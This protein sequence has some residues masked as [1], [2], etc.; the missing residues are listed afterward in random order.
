MERT[1]CVWVD[2]VPY[3]GIQTTLSVEENFVWMMDA[4]SEENA[5]TTDKFAHQYF[6][7]EIDVVVPHNKTSA[8]LLFGP[9]G[10]KEER[11]SSDL[12]ALSSVWFEGR[13]L[14]PRLSEAGP[15]LVPKRL[16]WRRLYDDVREWDP[17]IKVN[18]MCLDWGC[19]SI[20]GELTTQRTCAPMTPG[21]CD[22]THE[23]CFA[24]AKSWCEE[25]ERKAARMLPFGAPYQS[26]LCPGISH[27][28]GTH[29]VQICLSMRPGTSA[30]GPKFTGTGTAASGA[31]GDDD[32]LPTAVDFSG[33][34]NTDLYR[35]NFRW[36]NQEIGSDYVE[37]WFDSNTGWLTNLDVSRN[38]NGDGF[39]GDFWQIDLTDRAQWTLVG[40]RLR[41]R[42]G[43][44]ERVTRFK[45]AWSPVDDGN[46]WQWVDSGQEFEGNNADDY[47]I[48]KDVRFSERIASGVRFIRVYPTAFHRRASLR[49]SP[50]VWYTPTVADQGGW[51]LLARS[52]SFAMGSGSDIINPSYIRDGVTMTMD[53]S[54]RDW[55]E[56]KVASVNWLQAESGGYATAMGWSRGARGI[57]ECARRKEACN[58]DS[59]V[60]INVG[61]HMTGPSVTLNIDDLAT[62][63][64]SNRPLRCPDIVDRSNWFGTATLP[65][66]LAF[67]VSV[68]NANGQ[69]IVQRTDDPSS[70]WSHN[71]QFYCHYETA[72]LVASDPKQRGYCR[73]L[74]GPF[75]GSITFSLT[76]L[77]DNDAGGGIV[78]IKFRI[79]N[80]DWKHWQQRYRIYID[81]NEKFVVETRGQENRKDQQ[82]GLYGP[83]H[84]CGH[85]YYWEDIDVVVERT[86]AIAIAAGTMKLTISINYPQWSR[87]DLYY[88]DRLQILTATSR[89]VDDSFAYFPTDSERLLA[90]SIKKL[91]YDDVHMSQ[92]LTTPGRML[93]DV[94]QTGWSKPQTFVYRWSADPV[95]EVSTLKPGGCKSSMDLLCRVAHGPFDVKTGKEGVSKSFE[96]HEL[97]NE[98]SITLRFWAVDSWDG[99]QDQGIIQVDGTT[100]WESNSQGWHKECAESEW[101]HGFYEPWN[102]IGGKVCYW[103]VIL[104][105]IPHT[106]SKLRLEIS[107]PNLRGVHSTDEY[108]AFS[109]VRIYASLPSGTGSGL[110]AIV[111]TAR[112]PAWSDMLTLLYSDT[113]LDGTVKTDGWNNQQT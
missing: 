7:C 53:W 109:D 99:T 20:K 88:I 38:N 45:V 32:I 69:I 37:G 30:V 80:V 77:P 67:V 52:A 108:Y 43:N 36:N 15:A 34:E 16:A 61:A 86:D 58:E 65:A 72:G 13:V 21:F 1:C 93:M 11:R 100:V 111:D 9:F 78:R 3:V 84:G 59:S 74:R 91:V 90:P 8:E 51:A 57:A 94:I 17:V 25:E 98:V 28:N 75:D 42:R 64:R 112:S 56:Q 62:P 83:E 110:S 92:D 104:N 48:G 35:T 70:G 97:H 85:H 102:G 76:G 39:D 23:D 12:W 106:R 49:C 44:D 18:S 89:S 60:M 95:S 79:Y 63:G 113:N 73:V 33:S 96:I 55:Y 14:P 4:N 46:S 6:I 19:P 81:D 68:D 101:H 10:P 66:A 22:G 40:I 54:P 47:V 71:L 31:V 26:V 24:R 87:H 29:N 41:G 103:D 105:S 107:A 27:Q 82:G 2:N 50:L 5:E